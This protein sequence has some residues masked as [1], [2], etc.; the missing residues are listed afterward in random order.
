M[1]NH[2]P[3]EGRADVE[4]RLAAMW[5]EVLSVPEVAADD[6]FLDL[7]GNSLRAGE[8]AQRI[9][10]ELGVA[11]PIDVI[12]GE[13]TFSALTRAVRAAAPAR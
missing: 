9:R 3:L 8:M 6:N 7:G 10:A 4:A 2:E 11:V 5:R 13:E 12:L 1:T